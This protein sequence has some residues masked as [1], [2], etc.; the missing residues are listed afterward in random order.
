MHSRATNWVT[1][2]QTIQAAIDVAAASDTVLVSNGVYE[3]GGRVAPGFALTNRVVIDKAITVQS[4]N[5]PASTIIRGAGPLSDAGVRC[6]WMTN[7]ATLIGFTLTNGATQASGDVE[8]GGLWA[9]S[10]AVPI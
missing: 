9:Q 6:A 8:G 5:G 1:A 7:G 4:V 10:A 2:K 3:T